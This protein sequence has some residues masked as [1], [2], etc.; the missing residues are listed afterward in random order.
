MKAEHK[1]TFIPE[2]SDDAPYNQFVISPWP[3][4]RS[5]NHTQVEV[6]QTNIHLED[7]IVLMPQEKSPGKLEGHTKPKLNIS[8]RV[9]S[10]EKN[11]LMGRITGTI[12]NTYDMG[13]KEKNKENRWDWKQKIRR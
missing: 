9:L 3:A 12:H 2:W 4:T 8:P 11:D 1:S 10:L 13:R 5:E 7:R 6:E